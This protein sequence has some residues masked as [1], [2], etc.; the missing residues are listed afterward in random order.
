MVNYINTIEVKK[1]VRMKG[2]KV[3]G[4]V[5]ADMGGV[6]VMLSLASKETNFDY[7]RFFTSYSAMW[8]NVYT[9]K[10]VT[11]YNNDDVHPLS[12]IRVNLTLSQFDKF[13][14]TYDIK[15]GDGMYV[16]PEDRIA[17]W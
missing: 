15:E 3:N 2:S 16:A 8:A 7:R 1:N 9:D 14:E 17:I 4:E 6:K 10:A 13:V 12:Y 11:Y 5:T